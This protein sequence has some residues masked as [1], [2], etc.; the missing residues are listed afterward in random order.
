[1]RLSVPAIRIAA[2]ATGL[3]MAGLLPAA[4]EET[5]APAA[6]EARSHA[7]AYLAGRFAEQNSDYNTAATLLDRLLEDRPGDSA[8]QRRAFLSH[9]RAGNFARAEELALSISE[10]DLQPISTALVTLAAAD[11]RNNDWEQA[12]LNAERIPVS[13]LARYAAPMMKAWAQAGAGNPEAAVEALQE[14]S[15]SGGFTRLR[16]LHEGLILARAEQYDAAL[17]AL[18]DE[19]S[20]LQTAPVRLVR[21]VAQIHRIKGDDAAAET[22]LTSYL[23]KHPQTEIVDQDLSALRAGEAPMPLATPAQGVADGFYHLASGVRQQSDEV[24]LVYGRIASLLDPSLD[25]PL[26][27]VGTILEDRERYNEAIATLEQISAESSYYW[28]ARLAIADNLIDLDRDDAAIGLLEAM[29]TERPESTD[30]LV[31]I[32]YMMR[33]DK[34]YLQ[35][36]EIYNRAIGRIESDPQRRHWLLYYNRG[37]AFE[38][39]K[40]WPSAEADFLKALDLKPDDPFVLNYLGYSWVEQGQNIALAKE[41]IRK[42]VDQRQGDGYIVDSLGWVLFRIG[43]YEE[44]VGHLERAVQLR[45]QDPVINDHLGD[46]YWQVGRRNEARFQWDRALNLDPEEDLIPT[47]R[48]KLNNGMSAPEVIPI[49]N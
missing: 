33:A 41:M 36:V 4:A 30:P 42:A 46:A 29:A 39:S 13:G 21:T 32:G 19:V 27:L 35:E 20:D 7:G 15:D 37:I 9:L 47:I 48:N 43:Q 16:A 11:I 28:D 40:Q 2:F 10:K 18:L 25:L 31:K 6:V 12:L 5:V 38:R 44:A 17:K 1:M 3:T 8:M 24:A 14:L 23:E 34:E 49:A 22:V 45:P 26:L